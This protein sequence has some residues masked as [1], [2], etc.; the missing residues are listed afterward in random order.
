MSSQQQQVHVVLTTTHDGQDCVAVS[1]GD[2]GEKTLVLS[3]G[4]A[5]TLA[6]DLI[7]AV[8]RAEVKANLKVSHNLWRR[9]GESRPRL[10]PAG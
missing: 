7:S 6:N 2:A 10:Q 3:L 8:N 5:R 1:L 9:S 4:Q